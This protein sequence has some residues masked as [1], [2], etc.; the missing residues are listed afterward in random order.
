MM[1]TN[2]INILSY[3]WYN[4]IESFDYNKIIA[5]NIFSEVIGAYSQPHRYYHTLQHLYFVLTKIADLQILVK[6]LSVVKMAAFFHDFVYDTHANN[7]EEKSVEYTEK[8]L[9]NLSIPNSIINET[10]HLI[11]STKHHQANDIDAQVFLDA[12]LAILATTPI[13]YQAYTQAIRQEYHWVN[14]NEYIISRRQVLENFLQRQYIY[15]TP[16]MI[17]SSE[18]LARWNINTELQDLDY[19]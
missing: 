5:D 2:L 16:L 6:N 10:K 14:E 8:I 17:E 18:K 11:L 9:Q 13:E 7:N 1:Q 15:F 4:A 3:H 19:N 12:D